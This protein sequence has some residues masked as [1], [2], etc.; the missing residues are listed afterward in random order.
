MFGHKAKLH[1]AKR[2]AEKVQMKKTLK[3]YDERDV[4][5]KDDGPMQDGDFPEF[6][7]DRE[8]A[9]VRFGLAFPFFR[10]L[11]SLVPLIVGVGIGC[12]SALVRDQGPAKRPG[13]KVFGAVAE[14]A[15]DRRGGDVQGD[16]DGETQGEELEA[17]GEQGDV[18]R[19]ELYAQTGQ[20]GAV[21]PADGLGES[22]T[23]S[24][25]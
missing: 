6:M 1:H 23:R 17:D 2:H 19:G 4:K 20:A 3:A 16:Q 22:R 12:Q 10:S 9:K 21:H 11:V 25:G 14:G 5:Q 7:Y 18:R 24:G 8:E 13:C 15:G